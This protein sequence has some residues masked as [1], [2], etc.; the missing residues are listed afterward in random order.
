MSSPAIRID[1]VCK[2]YRSSGGYLGF[3]AAEVQAVREVSLEVPAGSAFGLVGQSGSGKSSLAR[4]VLGL[5]APDS[6]RIEIH[7]MPMPAPGRPGWRSMRRQV[8]MVFQDPY[9]SLNPLMSVAANI[10]EPLVNLTP[11]STTERESAVMQALA[12]VQL[13][14]RMLGAYPHQLSGGERQRVCIARALVL[15]P[16]V[17]VCDEAVSALDAQTQVQIVELLRELQRSQRLTYLF[18]SHD[19]AVVSRLC[20]ALAIMQQ[21]Q[22][23]ETGSCQRVL[24][25]PEHTYTRALVRAA[26]FFEPG[27]RRQRA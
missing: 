18:I 15:R 20:S 17:V 21:G 1:Q 23:V 24:Q 4:L 25:S 2:R 7:G 13:P 26:S 27:A 14:K 19:I 12:A 3:G 5:E 16:A 11:M 8:Q 10:A 6:G 22:I 9:T